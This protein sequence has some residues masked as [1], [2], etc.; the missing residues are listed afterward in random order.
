MK[1]IL[2][3]LFLGLQ[4]AM[5]FAGDIFHTKSISIFKNGTAFFRKTATFDASSGEVLL[6]NL[7]IANPEQKAPPKPSPNPIRW[8]YGSGMHS[9]WNYQHS[10]IDEQLTQVRFGTLW[11]FSPG[12][13]L[14]SVSRYNA[15]TDVERPV[16]DIPGIL[17]ENEGKPMEIKLKRLK[18]PLRVPKWEISGNFLCLSSEG[19]WVTAMLSEVEHVAFADKPDML[20]KRG[21]EPQSDAIGF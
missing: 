9:I 19:Q 16:R 21:S 11:F 6:S 5:L 4:S 12:N 15:P 20:E 17:R 14:K 7:S 13:P 8:Q 18:E 1:P 10:R 3:A 2:I